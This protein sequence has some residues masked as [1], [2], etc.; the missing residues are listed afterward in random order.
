MP[1]SP[2]GR[3]D[4]N[5]AWT[6][7]NAVQFAFTLAWTA[8]WISAALLVYALLRDRHWPLRMAS[9]CWAPGLLGGA[10]ARLQV[11]GLERV[12]WSRNHVFVANHQSTIDICA[13]FRA[14]PVPL[15]FLLKQEMTRVPF[16]G[17]YAKAMGMVFIDRSNRRAAVAFLRQSTELVRAGG[18]LCIF[19]EGTRSRSGIVAEFKGGA[20]QAAIDA[21]VDVVPV[22]IAGSGAVLYPEGFFH[23]RPGV[24]R[25]SF[26]APLPTRTADGPVD[27][28]ALA[29]D[30]H[31]AVLA[32]LG[33]HAGRA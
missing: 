17:W 13:L 4:R 28:Q 30:A 10:G 24:I 23:V 7:F 25:V 29:D 2:P 20:F 5:L 9:R 12:D 14:I 26:G 3:I 18:N 22:A 32:M 15:H 21:G 27:R 8:V 31:A 33:R 1:S 11:T 16:V 6:A 19:P